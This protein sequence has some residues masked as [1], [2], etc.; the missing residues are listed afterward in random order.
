M[1]PSII[2]NIKIGAMPSNAII[3]GDS[4][5]DPNTSIDDRVECVFNLFRKHGEMNYIGEDVSQLQHAQ[6]AAMCARKG[7]YPLHVIVGAFLHDIGI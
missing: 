1:N 4:E 6:Q 2:R 3:Y 7:D 5:V